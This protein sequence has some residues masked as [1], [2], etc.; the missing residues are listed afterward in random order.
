MSEGT[1][2]RTPDAIRRDI[3]HTREELAE[4]AAALVERADVKAR[5]DEKLDETKARFTHTIDEAKAKVTNTAGAAKEKLALTAGAS[6]ETAPGAASSPPAS[7]ARQAAGSL[8]QTVRENPL[9][10]ALVG[11]FAAGALI[12][13]LVARR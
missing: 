1:A 2:P 4:T 7:P 10:V 3:E 12:G 11:G 6:A 9:P 13:W 8:A 5:A